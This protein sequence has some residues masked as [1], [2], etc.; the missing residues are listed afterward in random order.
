MA[1]STAE[2]KDPRDPG[3]FLRDFRRLS[4]LGRLLLLCLP[5]ALI[6]E[7]VRWG[8][9]LINTQAGL[10]LPYINAG[11]YFLVAAF[12]LYV[13]RVSGIR[14]AAL[15]DRL[16][17]FRDRL[18]S[19]ADF[20]DRRDIPGDIVSSQKREVASRLAGVKLRTL[21]PVRVMHFAAPV[22]LAVSV[23]YP[24]VF[25]NMEWDGPE[26]VRR[27]S[28]G[29]GSG[30]VVSGEV[31]GE[32]P[33]QVI[34]PSRSGDAPHPEDAP[35]KPA[36]ADAAGPAD[37]ET[38]GGNRAESE[39]TRDDRTAGAGE[40]KA[41]PPAKPPAPFPGDPHEGSRSIK[42]ERIGSEVS[43]VVDPLFDEASGG[44]NGDSELPG[45]TMVFSLVPE[46]RS[47][48]N[49]AST[50]APKAPPVQ[51]SVDFEK[52]PEKYRQIVRRYFA[53]LER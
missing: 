10:D 36:A 25:D 28:R 13:R 42:S 17:S 3:K 23:S 21:V 46:M 30:E 14:A 32:G 2:E 49:G 44:V 35:P 41:R 22:L 51:I 27:I 8:A 6:N 34:D 15:A 47:G 1:K 43:E 4:L 20:R 29:S 50:A 52:I 39:E 48:E 26:I 9:A 5:A 18:T 7:G 37:P 24:T 33:D 11:P 40:E 38:D 16:L 45:G 19:Y 53:G 12:F 31:T